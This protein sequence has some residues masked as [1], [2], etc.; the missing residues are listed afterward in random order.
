MDER[1][2]NTKLNHVDLAKRKFE[3]DEIFESTI[4]RIPDL[5]M[6]ATFRWAGEEDYFNKTKSIQLVPFRK[7]RDFTSCISPSGDEQATSSLDAKSIVCSTAKLKEAKH[8]T[9]GKSDSPSSRKVKFSFRQD[10]SD[11]DERGLYTHTER[12]TKEAV[13]GQSRKW[14]PTAHHYEQGRE[15]DAKTRF[16]IRSK[17]KKRYSNI[18]IKKNNHEE[19]NRAVGYDKL[20]RKKPGPDYPFANPIADCMLTDENID[21]LRD[22]IVSSVNIEWK[23]LTPVRPNSEYE[24]KYFDKLIY[25]HR[26]RYKS[27]LESGYFKNDQ[28]VPFKHTR[29]TFVMQYG[30]RR[31]PKG[32]KDK[33]EGHDEDLNKAVEIK[34]NIPTLTLTSD[35]K[36]S[37][38][39]MN[40]D[41]ESS[42]DLDEFDYETFSRYSR[43]NIRKL[44]KSRAQELGDASEVD[45]MTNQGLDLNSSA[46][47]RDEP[48][49]MEEDEEL[50][51]QVESIISHLMST[52]LAG[53]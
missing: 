39:I 47:G 30:S 28:K 33:K 31:R 15:E 23:M 48:S 34:L 36:S 51:D 45:L 5:C 53:T 17:L 20:F 2:F 46:A 22:I 37:E 8:S 9:N 42:D 43:S 3:L 21:N 35:E 25:L 40:S 12:K 29:H 14:H 52:N 16:E 26:C 27:R 41:D 18:K 10:E 4:N 49:L 19:D 32:S 13:S 44:M 38:P 24:E 11:D 50:E 1:H 6:P 7:Q